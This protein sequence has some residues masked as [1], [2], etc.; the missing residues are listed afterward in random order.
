MASPAQSLPPASRLEPQRVMS[1]NLLEE[2]PGSLPQPAAE[3]LRWPGV[4]IAVAGSVGSATGLRV[5]VS[6]QSGRMAPPAR[7]APDQ[8]GPGGGAHLF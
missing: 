3:F 2:A 1:P 8:S 5:I 6:W 7:R 4:I